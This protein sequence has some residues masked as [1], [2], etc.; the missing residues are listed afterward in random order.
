MVISSKENEKFKTA[1][2]LKEKKHRA[3][4]GF[5]VVEGKKII[6]DL[7]KNKIKLIEE[8]IAG[9]NITEKL[10]K[11]LTNTDGFAIFEVPKSIDYSGGRFIVCDNIQDAGNM[12]T[13]CRTALAFG[14]GTIFNINS[15]DT[16]SE[17][18]IRAS[19]GAVFNLNIIDITIQDFLNLFNTQ[20]NKLG[21]TLYSANLNGKSLDAFENS[22]K[23]FGIILGSEGQGVSKEL[24]AASD[25]TITIR[26]QNT[27][28]SL[29]VAVSAGIIMHK[30]SEGNK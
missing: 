21:I 28:E 19:S 26:M 8:F 27:L 30:L 16:F 24:Q 9:V 11:E 18:V 4:T 1:K 10:Y 14:F 29:N 15:A 6:N 23:N 3:Q 13:I 5:C 25:A 2:K 20:K 22:A 17:K 12:G 7:I